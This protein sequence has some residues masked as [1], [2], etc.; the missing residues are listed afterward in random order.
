MAR[1]WENDLRKWAERPSDNEDSQR[2]RT[3][4][5]V[6]AALKA[7]S[8]LK[9]FSYR[10][11][12]K[13]SYANNTNVR[14]N[15]DVDIAVECRDFYLHDLSGQA[16]T[17]KKAE[18]EASFLG[19]SGPGV[20][21]FRQAIKSALVAQFGAKAVTPG[22]IAFRIREGKTT[23]PA[24]VVPCFDYHRIYD[25]D[26]KGVLQFHGGTKLFPTTGNSVV[27]WPQQQLERG[28]EKNNATGRRYKRMV[29][30]L[31][32]L[33]KELLDQ[34]LLKVELASFLVE[35]L[36]YNVPDNLFGHGHYL[37]D[38]KGVLGTVYL[39]TAEESKCDEWLEVNRL[40]YLLRAGQPW[41]FDQVHQLSLSAWRYMGLS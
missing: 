1:D 30:A 12:A 39:A 29:R 9:N 13:G 32:K 8:E 20:D 22:K 24:D 23:L 14:L 35:C 38:M 25:I 7:S 33:Q 2:D 40:K 10:V 15:Y 19:Y 17:A 34:K 18:V 21:H 16:K 6:K 5:Q 11:Y 28:I 37:D 41:T 3:E 31:K 4:T 27:N 36:V 26:G